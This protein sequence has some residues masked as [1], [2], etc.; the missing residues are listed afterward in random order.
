MLSVRWK[1]QSDKE[2]AQLKLVFHGLTDSENYLIADNLNYD[3]L[4]PRELVSENKWKK[5]SDYDRN[6]VL[7]EDSQ[8]R[9]WKE[10]KEAA[11]SVTAN[12]VTET[13]R[14]F[15]QISTMLTV[16]GTIFSVIWDIP[17]QGFGLLL[18]VLKDLTGSMLYSHMGQSSSDNFVPM[19]SP[20]LPGLPPHIHP[21]VCYILV[22][23]KLLSKYGA[24]FLIALNGLNFD[25]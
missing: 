15:L 4:S 12:D 13:C 11:M 14:A 6:K 20:P 22:F 25:E 9:Y 23:H 2:G 1:D 16:D 7:D 21:E 19:R 10:S 5:M 8:W 24:M 3:S 17:E 18:P